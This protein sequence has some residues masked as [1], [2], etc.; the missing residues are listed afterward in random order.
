[1]GFVM[2]REQVKEV[3]ERVLTWPPE[4]QEDAAEILLSIEA[5]DE[6]GYRL[7]DDQL[8][9]LQRRRAE[10]DPKTLTLSEFDERLRRFG[11]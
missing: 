5:Q 9:E 3:L 11:V 7:S 1:M 2:T 10:K 4:R 8:T 6:S